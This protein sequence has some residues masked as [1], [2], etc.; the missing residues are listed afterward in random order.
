M[1][2]KTLYSSSLLL[3]FF[4]FFYH[5]HL[6]TSHAQP[7]PNTT[8]ITCTNQ[9]ANPCQTYAFY[10]ASAPDF[11]DLASIA[12]L[13]SVSRLMISK[14]SNISAPNSTLVASQPLFVPLT[15]SCNYASNISTTISYA[16]ISYTINSGDTFYL[17]STN[18]FQNLTTYQSVMVVNPS[19][20]P[21]NLSIGVNA[22]FPIFC[23]CPNR[24]QL[25]NQVNYLVSYVFQPSDNLSIIA[26]SFGVQQQSIID[27]NGDNFQPF[28]TIFIPVTRLPV[29]SQP[30]VA[31]SPP[32]PPPPPSAAAEETDQREGVV[33]GL[34]IGL[35]ITGFLL[36]LLGGLW[37]YRETVLKNRKGLE[38]DREKQ[39]QLLDMNGK[40]LKKME[41]NLMA[42]VSDC[43]D[44]YKVFKIEDLKEATDGF[45][46]SSL[47]Q[48]SVYKGCIDGEVYAI[49]K[50]KWNAYEE[51][52][53]LQKVK[54]LFS[55]IVQSLPLIRLPMK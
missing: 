32:P 19:L 29:L 2:T 15:C 27:V 26:S 44:K 9:T 10:Q 14:P 1:K 36:L 53:I 4:F 45:S 55:H 30:A 39:R 5:H 28:N 25:Q 41:S 46:E 51:L 47:I 22:I 43:L 8:G 42:D 18:K 35:G 7:A 54:I 33:T 40:G 16:N 52:K 37:V 11:L 49:K 38:E 13:F 17:V 31:P 23:K 12:D 48:G 21:T 6:Q 20:V 3:F 50:M 34:A 24:T